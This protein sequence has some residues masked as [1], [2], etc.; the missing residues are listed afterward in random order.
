MFK[1]I[2]IS[3][4]MSVYNS[5][6]YLKEAID[7]ILNQSMKDFEFIITDDCST[8]NSLK[9]IKNYSKL[10]DRIIL[11]ENAENIGLTKSLNSMIGVT[12]GK[13]IA[14]MDADDISLSSRFKIQYDFM[15]NNPEIGVLGTYSKS[16]GANIKPRIINRPLSHEEI[17]STL[18]FENLMVHSSVF[19]RKELFN[20]SINRYNDDFSIIQDYELWSRLIDLTR[21]ANIPE[22]LLLYRI[23]DT[24]ICNTT[25][26]NK[27]YRKCF[28]NR[29]HKFQLDKLGLSPSNSELDLHYLISIFIK[30]R[31][32]QNVLKGEK[33]LNILQIQNSQNS[34]YSQKIFNQTL[35]NYWF[36]LCTKSTS[37][38]LRIIK[39]YYKS[40]F[41]RVNSIGIEYK[42]KFLI[43][44]LIRY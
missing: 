15:E 25:E 12:K 31:E 21:F 33:W 40:D 20:E 14:R 23:S 44:C 3:V 4:I 32:L 1:N 37:I 30:N 7:S 13:Y 29:I 9:I 11:L 2:K 5:E 10:D 18:L 8:D 27:N 41:S 17:K 22:A 19:I 6:N 16:F 28:L 38:G 36:K 34:I 43:K 42:L 35:G 39:N 26:N 24:N